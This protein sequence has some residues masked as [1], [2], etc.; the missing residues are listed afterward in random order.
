ME[1]P[2]A[3]VKPKLYLDGTHCLDELAAASNVTLEGLS[4][5]VDCVLLMR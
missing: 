1:G 2:V 4:L 5:P 3:P